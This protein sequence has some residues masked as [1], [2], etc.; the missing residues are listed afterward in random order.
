MHLLPVG[1]MI[2]FDCAGVS[3]YGRTGAPGLKNSMSDWILRKLLVATRDIGRKRRV[4]LKLQAWLL[5][6][7]QVS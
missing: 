6:V 1:Q 3:Q 5:L 2:P 4:V 7:S